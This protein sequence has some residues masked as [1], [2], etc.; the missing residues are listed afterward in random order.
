GR[1]EQAEQVRLEDQRV[2]GGRGGRAVDGLERQRYGDGPVRHDGTCQ[3]AR[4][5]EQ[6]V[7]FDD[8]VD[9][10]DAVRLVRVDHVA[11]QDHL[12][13][14]AAAYQP[15]EPDRAA[16]AGDD[17]ELDLGQAEARVGRRDAQ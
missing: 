6:R 8:A 12:E 4:R 7:G 13:R 3:A 2:L 5:L 1:G 11:G 9:E 15:L 16:V 14:T 10:P 17:A